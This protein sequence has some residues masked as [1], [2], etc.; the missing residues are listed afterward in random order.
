MQTDSGHPALKKFFLRLNRRPIAVSMLTIALLGAAAIAAWRLP[1]ELLPKGFASSTIT[2]TAP[3]QGANPAEIEQRIIR[4]LEEE[5]RTIRGVKDVLAVA[6]SG[7]AIVAMTFPGDF[8]MDQAH[9]EVADRIERVRPLLPRD[10]DRVRVR[11]QQMSSFPIIFMGVLYPPEDWEKSQ[12]VLGDLLQDRLEAIDGVASASLRGI[13]PASIRILLD[14]EQV[15]ANRV[16]IGALMASLQGDNLSLPAGDLDEGGKRHIVRVDSRFQSMEELE[17]F[18]VKPGLTIRDIGRVQKVRSAPEYIFRINGKYAVSVGV[19]KET[20]ANTFA[21]CNEVERVVKEVFPLDPELGNFEFSVY[22]SQGKNIQSTLE[23]LVK[24]AATGGLIA[25]GILW[26]FLRRL[27]YTLLIAVSIPF[28]VLLTLAWIYFR[29]ESFNMLSMMGITISIGMLVDNSVVI[30]ESILSR[31]EKG[32]GLETACADGPS[33]VMLAVITAT[34]TT[35]V[36]FLPLIFMSSDRNAK[37]VSSAIGFPLCISLLAALFLA[38]IIVPVASRNLGDTKKTAKA[39]RQ[40]RSLGPLQ[41]GFPKLVAW[42]LRNRFRALSLA[43]IFLASY[44][45]ADTG[46]SFTE[47]MGMGSQMSVRLKFSPNRKIWE[48]EKD[49]VAIENSLT[50]EVKKQLHLEDFGIDFNRKRGSIYFWPDTPP[51]PE[52]K[53]AS[54]AI[55][56]E[57]LPKLAGL[58]YRFG[59]DFEQRTAQGDGRWTRVQI[60]GPDSVVVEELA[61]KIRQEATAKKLFKEIA[62]PNEIAREIFVSLDREQMARVG[63]NSQTVVGSIEWGL[64]GFMIS[65]FQTPRADLPLILEYDTPGNPS[66][67]DLTELSIWT[68][69]AALPL[70]TM[71]SFLHKR[72]P[73]AISR[74]NGQTMTQIGFKPQGKD[75]KGNYGV[76]KKLMDSQDFPEG[77]RWK[78]EGGWQGFNDDMAELQS[79]FILAVALV[80]LLMGLLFDSIALPFSVLPTI[81]FAIVGAK[82]AFSIFGVQMDLLGAVGM[83]VLAGIVVNNGIVLVDRILRLENRGMPRESAVIQAVS[84]RLRPVVMTALTTIVGLLPIALSKPTGEGFNFQG[85]AVGVAGGLAFTTF[86]TLWTV[87]L[88]YTLLRDLGDYFQGLFRRKTAPVSS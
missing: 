50:A 72:G 45:L 23:N 52:E 16:D 81:A 17:D 46:S 73:T 9:A 48:I 22:W 2:V 67:A 70:S 83:I 76:V 21:V 69:T 40:S 57:T 88:L 78:Q 62:K 41:T 28:S 55:L 82:W 18:P 12:D 33:E 38:I 42:G 66:K 77:Y 74:R 27:R 24:D 85:L 60:E 14:E 11:R 36:V 15:I 6:S 44:G 61:E 79:A 71:A 51:S 54:F 7:N 35:V 56:R 25:I 3:W 31:R 19:S 4:P 34:L 30:V 37:L 49:I 29:G 53:E 1:V 65:R 8:D 20:S 86:F 68:G 59:D 13:S 87:P 84:D 39:T 5:L 32:D 63:V 26:I 43:G 75:M 47:N 80:F 58:S 64:R 10:V